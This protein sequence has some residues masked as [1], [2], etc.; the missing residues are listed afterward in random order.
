MAAT[1]AILMQ[2]V[3]SSIL[4]KEAASALKKTVKDMTNGQ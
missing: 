3:V 1:E 2:Q 4:S